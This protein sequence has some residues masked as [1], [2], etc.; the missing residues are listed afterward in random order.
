MNR[1]SAVKTIFLGT[2]GFLI[3]S[4]NSFSEYSLNEVTLEELILPTFSEL[5]SYN[6]FNNL[7]LIIAGEEQKLYFLTEK[8]QKIQLIKTYPISTGK[9]GFGNKPNSGRTPLGIHKIIKKY[10]DNAPEGTIFSHLSNTGRI[11]PINKDSS[12]TGY[13]L[14]T[15]RILR[16]QGCEEQN[17]NTE[18][19]HIYIH[20]ISNEGKIGFPV[21]SGCIRMKNSDIIELYSLIPVGTYINIKEKIR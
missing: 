17:C 19:R 6:D 4:L 1:R 7:A 18:A 3:T 8:E 15:S 14:I 2:T 13:S 9:Y 21:S 5:K 10:G 11:A 12:N 20:G 16:L